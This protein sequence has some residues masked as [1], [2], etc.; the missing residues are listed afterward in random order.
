MVAYGPGQRKVDFPTHSTLLAATMACVPGTGAA[1][2]QPR[3]P[4]RYR[5]RTSE[6][7]NPP[8]QVAALRGCSA[9]GGL[10]RCTSAM[11]GFFSDIPNGRSRLFRLPGVPDRVENDVRDVLAGERSLGLA[12]LAP[13]GGMQ[14]S[15]EM[16]RFP[17]LLL[18]GAPSSRAVSLRLVVGGGRAGADEDLAG[19]LAQPGLGPAGLLRRV[20][21]DLD[22]RRR[23]PRPAALAPRTRTREEPGK[24]APPPA[25]LPEQVSAEPGERR[26]VRDL[27]AARDP[28][29]RI[30]AAPVL[31]RPGGQ[32]PAQ[33]RINL[34]ETRKRRGRRRMASGQLNR[35]VAEAWPA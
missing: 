31:H 34:P 33:V 21:G 14:S 27:P 32:H 35:F 26:V 15:G 7:V 6:H 25:R 16:Q 19:E 8:H 12:G 28:E 30:V 4:S 3:P 17:D 5:Y 24:T 11:A 13:V 29:R 23:P 18:A 2:N 1:K 22:P 20:R 9:A 10:A